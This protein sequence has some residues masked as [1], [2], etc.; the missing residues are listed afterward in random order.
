M[1]QDIKANETQS[2]QASAIPTITVADVVESAAAAG[3]VQR[4]DGTESHTAD[5]SN[6]NANSTTAA[7]EQVEV[8]A[9][10]EE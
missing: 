4:Q 8:E 7:T 2:T 5:E 10:G 6:N 9:S 3:E 1:I